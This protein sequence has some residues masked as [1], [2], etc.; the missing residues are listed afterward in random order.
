MKRTVLFFLIF[1]FTTLSAELIEISSQSLAFEVISSDEFSTEL[2]LN[3]GRFTTK[4]VNID[5]Q[6]FNYI[7]LGNE[8]FLMEKG[9]PQLPR[10]TRSIIIPDRKKA[11][12]EIIETEFTDFNL[13]VAP[14]KG[15]FTRDINPDDVPW[16]F[17]DAYSND[18]F[19]PN[20]LGTTSSPFILR[21][22]RGLTVTAQPFAYNHTT[23]TMRVYHKL[24]LKIVYSDGLGDNSLERVNNKINIYFDEVYR[25]KFLNY[26]YIMNT[27]YSELDDQG[28]MI[29]ICGDDFIDEI[30]P[31]VEWKRQK[32]IQTDLYSVSQIG[33]TNTDIDE[34]IRTEYNL[35]NGLTF[36]QL[37]GD[38]AQV[39]SFSYDGGGSDPTYALQAGGDSYPDIFV[40]RFSGESSADI[41]TQVE[42]SIYYE[43]DI[44][45]GAWLAKATGIASDQGGSNG[46]DGETDIEHQNVIRNKLMNYSYTEVDQIYDPSASV[47]DVATAVNE[48]RGLIDY[49]G[50]GSNNS[51]VSSGFSSTHVN[52]LTN[53]YML[54]FIN[55]VACVNGNFVSMTCFA[56]TWMR[57]TN[58]T[59]GAPT[60]AIAIFASSINQSWAPPMGA[61]DEFID[62]LCGTGAYAGQGNRFN[63]IGGL[64]YNSESQML[65]DYS[66]STDM[67]KTWHIFG[68]ASLQVRTAEPTAVTLNHSGSLFV[69]ETTYQVS[70]GLPNIMVSLY[71]GTNILASGIT[72]NSGNISL[73]LVDSPDDPATLTLTVT[74]YNKITN[75]Q[76]VDVLLN[77]GP[78]I[79]ISNNTIQAGTDAEIN[80]DETVNLGFTLNNLGPEPAT[81]VTVTISSSDIY[82]NLQD[83]QET[84][85]TIAANSED[86]LLNAFSFITLSGIPHQHLISLQVFISSDQDNWNYNL[87]FPVINPAEISLPQETISLQLE[88]DQFSSQTMIIENRGGADLDYQLSIIEDESRTDY[89]N[90]AYCEAT[91]GGDEY[92]SNV[93]IG[94]IINNS[95]SGNYQDFTY[96]STDVTI[97]ENY[98]IQISLDT[99]YSSDKGAVWVDWNQDEDFEDQ[100]ET[101]I[102][103]WSGIG[104]YEGIITIPSHAL[105]GE[106]RMRVRLNYSSIP[107]YCGTT[108]WGEVEDYTLNV[109]SSGPAWV[110]FNGVHN[111]SGTVAAGETNHQ[112]ELSFDVTGLGTG[113]YTGQIIVNSNS[114][115]TPQISVP[116]TL[117]VNE[118]GAPSPEFSI[119]QSE[120][121]LTLEPNSTHTSSFDITNSGEVGS[122]L[123]YSIAIEYPAS[124]LMRQQEKLLRNRDDIP[125]HEFKR[126]FGEKFSKNEKNHYKDLLN[127]RTNNWLSVEPTSGDITASTS[128]QISVS[129][130]TSDLDAGNYSAT[131]EINN[132]AGRSYSF[133]VNITID[134]SPVDPEVRNIAEFEPMSGALVRH[135]FGVPYTVMAEISED[136]KLYT[137]VGSETIKN[138]VITSY[139]NNGVNLTNCVFLIA[140]TDSY[141][142]RDYGPWFVENNGSIDIVDFNYNRPLRE[143][144]N[145]IPD[146]MGEYFDV[147]TYDLGLT[148][149]GGNYMTDGMGV[150]VSSD[151]AYTENSDLT[152][153]QVDGTMQTNLGID[154]Y[155]VVPDPNDSYI[156]HVDCWGKFLAVDKLLIRSVPESDADYQELEDTV[157]YFESIISSYGTPYQIFRVYTPNDEPYT[158]SLILNDK[159]YV[160]IM[161]SSWDD[162]AIEVYEQAMPGYEVIGFTNTTTSSW[163]GTDALHC[164]VKEIADFGMLSITHIPASQS[165]EPSRSVDITAQI[166]AYSGEEVYTEECKVY[167]RWDEEVYNSIAMSNVEGNNYAASIPGGFAGQT[168]SYYISAADASGRVETNPVMGEF[169]PHQVIV[170]GGLAKPLNISITVSETTFTL[171]WDDVSNAEGYKIYRSTQPYSN[172]EEIGTTISSTYILE[173]AVD[174]ERYFFRVTAY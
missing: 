165:S 94:D 99:I 43:R 117:Q 170:T 19:Y 91:A 110:S 47:P 35:N 12:L 173:N 166:I 103:N 163:Q 164:R 57:A 128:N 10:V 168:L 131:L 26:D 160:P 82:I 161:N 142:T 158:N 8:S 169:N 69:G 29:V 34:F 5:N 154:N 72:N 68:D 31:W 46:D 15:N 95:A 115:T 89:S 70:T 55:S 139:S 121:N 11:R 157:D 167:Y 140:P 59:T 92:I 100:D 39:P 80:I 156:D 126:L 144:D 9:A 40:G 146:F 88:T 98:P 109:Q 87:N 36:V 76:N 145:E 64:W 90:R 71:D 116:L 23:Q 83:A 104:P 6:E 148:H 101:V 73:D 84:V 37:V 30:E 153:S 3:F 122:T 143:D 17:G 127:T 137:L 135:P 22:F 97:G 159:V 49:T 48:G 33:D 113:S 162:E 151:I 147:D 45:D 106:T 58:N 150:S 2:E 60:G 52:L 141:W 44:V 38:A 136:D 152:E 118:T 96:L 86:I 133:P 56:E 67:Y 155:Y 124:I 4:S 85:G 81:G 32:G 74:G 102:D 16:L 27:R 125:E 18:E 172:Y 107:Q 53:D 119:N 149:T 20:K 51:W 111:L 129:I 114:E 132:N 25:T 62:L 63:T 105:T 7:F 28:R 50:H 24:K 123:S 108:N 79:N 130:D 13:K 112:V 93:T 66:T 42:R 77:S 171:S 75:T 174:T 41:T 120:I 134:S 61:Q 1:V 65:D 21:D 14:S 138:T 78:F 54:P